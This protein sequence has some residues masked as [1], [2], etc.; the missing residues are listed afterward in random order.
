M[1]AVSYLPSFS[2]VIT[3]RCVLLAF[4]D[5]GRAKGAD[6]TR[7][8]QQGAV[9]ALHPRRQQGR[10]RPGTLSSLRLMLMALVQMQLMLVDPTDPTF[11]CLQVVDVFHA[12]LVVVL[13]V[14]F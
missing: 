6:G 9:C 3:S 7:F 12:V 1:A 14:Y 13:V 4:A 10:P 8:L 2:I 5:G 11:T